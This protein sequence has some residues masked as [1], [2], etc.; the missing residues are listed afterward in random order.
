M[1]E[2]TLSFIALSGKEMKSNG[3][4]VVGYM[5]ADGWGEGVVF[6]TNNASID[7]WLLRKEKEFIH[8]VNYAHTMLL[9]T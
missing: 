1:L 7:P 4:L 6:F 8:H 9:G 3:Y 2:S 5:H